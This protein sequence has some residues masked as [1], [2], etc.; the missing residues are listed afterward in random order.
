MLKK[1]AIPKPAEQLSPEEEIK[2]PF[3]L[4]F[5]GLKDE[6]RP[7]LPDEKILAAKLESKRRLLESRTKPRKGGLP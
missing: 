4:E 7:T 6:Y 5:L 1:G 2:D 3:V